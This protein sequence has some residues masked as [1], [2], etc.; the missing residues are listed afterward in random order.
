[1]SAS[2]VKARAEPETAED[3]SDPPVEAALAASDACSGSRACLAIRTQS[4]P[5]H[6]LPAGRS[7][8]Q[9]HRSEARRTSFGFSRS[10]NS[11]RSRQVL[12]RP[13]LYCRGDIRN[14]GL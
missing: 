11:A 6:G 4:A 10:L 1:M 2:A 3:L 9:A 5:S 13:S 12:L 7:P 8:V 14:T